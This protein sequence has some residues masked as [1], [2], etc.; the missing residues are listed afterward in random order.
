[1]NTPYLQARDLQL[2]ESSTSPTIS[3]STSTNSTMMVLAAGAIVGAA[4]ALAFAPASGRDTRSYLGQRS[5]R[6]AGDVA[7]RGR[8]IWA[9]QGERVTTAVRRGYTEA[10]HTLEQVN[11]SDNGPRVS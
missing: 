7:E 5:R 8:R 10:A 3:T 6:L 9:E 1:M 4:V 2:R 11:A